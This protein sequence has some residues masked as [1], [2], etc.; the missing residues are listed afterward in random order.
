MQERERGD[1]PEQQF[2]EPLFALAAQSSVPHSPD[3][4]LQGGIAACLK[5]GLAAGPVSGWGQ[6]LASVPTLHSCPARLSFPSASPTQACSASPGS[7][8]QQHLLFNFSPL[9]SHSPKVGKTHPI[10]P[11]PICRA[12]TVSYKPVGVLAGEG[13]SQEELGFSWSC[14]GRLQEEPAGMGAAAGSHLAM[15]AEGCCVVSTA[16][17]TSTRS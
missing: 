6:E 10:P 12:G 14:S 9:V 8:E 1:S 4:Q 13:T 7:G 17:P 5:P 16:S 2:P 15:G 11:H 3:A